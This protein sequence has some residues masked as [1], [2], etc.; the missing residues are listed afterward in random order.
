[1]WLEYFR[2]NSGGLHHLLPKAFNDKSNDKT[3]IEKEKNDKS[4]LMKELEELKKAQIEAKKRNSTTQSSLCDESTMTYEVSWKKVDP[5]LVV[6]LTDV[7]KVV[8]VPKKVVE[9]KKPR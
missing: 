3:M 2:S 1:M 5:I 7:K 4:E 6:T 9:E 8:F